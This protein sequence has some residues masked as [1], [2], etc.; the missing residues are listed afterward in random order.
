VFTLFTGDTRNINLP[1]D[2]RG[3]DQWFN[4]NAG[5]NRNSSQQLANEVRTS[6]L[7]F[8]NIRG[9]GLARWDLSL[10]KNF[11]I[12]ERAKVQF[13]AEATNVLNH[14]NL[15]YGSA[16]NTTPTSSAFGAYSTHDYTRRFSFMLLVK[17]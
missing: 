3:V 1:K 9:D 10:F 4:V 2:Q 16:P 17:F 15:G 5:F 13:R 8:S 7:R 6:P 12:R 11:R 14:P